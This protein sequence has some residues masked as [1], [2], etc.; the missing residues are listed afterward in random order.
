MIQPKRERLGAD[1]ESVGKRDGSMAG[2]M[3]GGQ[4]GV[5]V[6][7]CT[8]TI[9][10]ESS[11]VWPIITYRTFIAQQ[12]CTVYLHYYPR[13]IALSMVLLLMY[14]YH[15]AP[16]LGRW[17]TVALPRGQAR[18]ASNVGTLNRPPRRASQ[19]KTTPLFPPNN[20]HP[21]WYFFLFISRGRIIVFLYR[22]GSFIL[23]VCAANGLTCH[24]FGSRANPPMR[25]S[26]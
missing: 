14:T 9:F 7:K 8:Y 20:L 26:R 23:F 22:P 12:C 13:R 17:L 18:R 2:S 16:D 21:I 19:D 5:L 10:L 11:R 3:T 6:Y 1:T 25:T 15:A 24:L 4:H